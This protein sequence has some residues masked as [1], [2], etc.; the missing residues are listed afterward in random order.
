MENISYQT[1]VYGFEI[2]L[3]RAVPFL[4]GVRVDGALALEELKPLLSVNFSLFSALFSF[5]AFAFIFLIGLGLRN[6]FRL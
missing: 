5:L 1:W 4:G 6:R 3:S 2:T